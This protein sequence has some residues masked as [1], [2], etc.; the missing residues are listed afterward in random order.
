[1]TDTIRQRIIDAVEEKGAEVR[2]SKGYRTDI[3]K[4]IQLYRTQNIMVPAIGVWP[5][6]EVVTQV[7][8]EN[9]HEMPVTIE[10]IV[11]L[12]TQDYHE[13]IEKILGDII[14]MMTG[15][16]FTIDYLNGGD[17][18][19]NPEPGDVILGETSGAAAIIEDF[20]TDSGS[21]GSGDAAGF[22]TLRRLAGVFEAEDLTID[23]VTGLAE[24]AGS[25]TKTKAEVSTGGGLVEDIIL[26]AAGRDDSPE[27]GEQNVGSIAVFNVIYFTELG[28]P[29]SQP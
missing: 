24:T 19:N 11:S 13:L 2:R 20:T 22:F 5:G 3:G 26:V 15:T 14:E 7:H 21:W 6:T 16:K 9:R 1:M 12:G 8:G 27:S 10:G 23:G 18:T 29:Y 28:N 25:V 17:A 4:N